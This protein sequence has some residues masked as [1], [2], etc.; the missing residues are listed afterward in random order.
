M[1]SQRSTQWAFLCEFSLEEHLPQDHL[2]RVIDR[3]VDLGDIR[4]QLNPFYSLFGRHSID[5]ELLIRMLLVEYCFGIRSERRLLDEVHLNLACSWFCRRVLSDWVPDHSIFS[6][7]RHGRFRDSDLFRHLFGIVLARC[8]AEGLVGRMAFGADASIIKAEASRYTK[9]KIETWNV[10]ELITRAAQ[11]YLDRLDDAAFGSATP[12][13][14]KTISPSDPAARFTG[15]NGDRAFFAYSTN[16]LVDLD[17]A[18]I[19]DVQA[20]APV[21]QAEVGAVRDM[22]IRT[23]E[24]F[25]LHPD[26]LAA[27]TAYGSAEMPGWLFKG[28]GIAPHIPVMD[29]SE[30]ND[31]AFPAT[32]FAFDSDANE[33]TC[34][35]GK[36]LKKYWRTMT[37][38]RSGLC[39]DGTYRYYARK[40]DCSACA[41]KSKCTPN[42][43]IRK[44]ARHVHEDARERA[45]EIARTEDYITSGYA[46][47]KVEML[48]A[49]L[50]LMLKFDRLRLR[51]PNGA[52]DEFHLA[53]IAQN[54]RKLAKLVPH[55]PQI[56]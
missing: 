44:I 23:A 28:Q 55:V 19:V 25:D 34:P 32:A 27:D 42:Q 49:H 38:E 11:E 37:K 30:R 22:L 45:R 2:I 33:Y 29:K 54:L 5:P 9:A 14:P 24:R 41:L 35:G 16:Y 39:K 51:G 20:T 47:K 40:T 1:G 53:A 10:P 18:V 56:A 3:F 26:K 43:A 31:G 46:R 15:A 52:K 21:R 6:K 50:K 7:N 36:K 8:I 12:V 17:N 13:Q 4:N 48:F